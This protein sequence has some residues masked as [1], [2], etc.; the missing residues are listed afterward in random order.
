M[1]THNGFCENHIES[2]VVL[3]SMLYNDLIFISFLLFDL[4]IYSS[5]IMF[6]LIKLSAMRNN[7][8]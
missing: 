4:I 7:I 6:M 8:N 1:E 5:G 3:F 2:I